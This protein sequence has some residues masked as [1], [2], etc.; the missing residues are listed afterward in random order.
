VFSS[1]VTPGFLIMADPLDIP[2]PED[3]GSAL[4]PSRDIKLPA[5][6]T[7]RP[8]AWFTYIESHFRLR[9]IADEQIQ[10]DHVL[11]ALP[12]D[13]VGQILD[14]VEAAPEATPYTFLKAR[15]LET[16][17]LSDYEKPTPPPLRWLASPQ[18]FAFS[19]GISPTGRRSANPPAVGETSCQGTSQ[20]RRPWATGSRGGPDFQAAFLSGHRSQFL[21]LPSSFFSSTI[22]P[23]PFWPCWENHPL[24]GRDDCTT[25]FRQ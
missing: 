17:Q 12:E 20:R 4:Q 22:G 15:I 19:T 16:H 8:R 14:L 10:F 11:S 13:M 25:V 24:L 18:A 9:G 7:T 2:L 3:V 5:F 21:H 23:L 1:V 6:W